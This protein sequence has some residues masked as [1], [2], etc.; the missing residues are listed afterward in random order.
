[1]HDDGDERRQLYVSCCNICHALSEGR[2]MANFLT[3]T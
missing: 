3:D 1:M 2:E